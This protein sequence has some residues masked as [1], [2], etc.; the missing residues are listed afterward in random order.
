M[1]NDDQ[2]YEVYVK[3]CKKTPRSFSNWLV[4][5]YRLK[6]HRELIRPMIIWWQK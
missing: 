4:L 1:M 2:R 6:H 3:N 5:T